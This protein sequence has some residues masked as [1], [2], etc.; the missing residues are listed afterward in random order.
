[1][2]R[3]RN[4]VLKANAASSQ[5]Y[6]SC[7]TTYLD[8]HSF[9][10]S[11]TCLDDGDGWQNELFFDFHLVDGLFRVGRSNSSQKTVTVTAT[12]PLPPGSTVR[13]ETFPGP[14]PDIFVFTTRYLTPHQFELQTTRT[15]HDGG[16]GQSLQVMYYFER[17]QPRQLVIPL[18][19][20]DSRN[21]V[22]TV[23]TPF[24]IVPEPGPKNPAPLLR[25]ATLSRGR[26]SMAA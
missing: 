16:W 19:V 20:S 8:D 17:A 1:M 12:E 7:D 25:H 23:Y 24:P 11:V 21:K 10:L 22:V 4:A 13:V 2:A 9:A 5:A 26:F 18:G 15:D 14:H 3:V 6:F